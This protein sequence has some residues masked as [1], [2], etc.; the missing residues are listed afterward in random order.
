[1]KIP[2]SLP[3]LL[4]EMQALRSMGFYSLVAQALI[5][6]AG[7]GLVIGLFR[8]LYTHINAFIV[9]SLSLHNLYSLP[10]ICGLFA[11]LTLLALISGW[12]VTKEPLLSGSGIPQVELTVRGHLPLP[13][14][15]LLLG[16]FVGTLLCL[17]GGLSVGREGPSIQMGAAVG[18]GVGSLWFGKES[19]LPRFLIAGSA[20]GMTAAFGAPCAGLLFAFEEMKTV[21]TVPLLLFTACAAGAAFMVIHLLFGFG[22]VYPFAHLAPLAWQQ[23]PLLL[24][25]AAIVGFIGAGYNGALMGGLFFWDKQKLFSSRTR[26]LIPFVC[27]GLLLYTYPQVLVGF[28]ISIESLEHGTMLL[29]S[30]LVLLGVKILFSILSFSSGVSGGLLMPMLSIGAMAGACASALALPFGLIQADQLGTVLTL[31]MGALFAATVRAPLTGGM[32]V[33][34]MTGA[35]STAPAMLVAVYTA[36]FVAN[37]LHSAP[38]YDSIKV[39]LLK[40]TRLARHKQA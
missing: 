12:I 5:V 19:V 26:P 32:L 38:I 30:L 24:V 22:L 3:P 16:K 27:S 4:R 2:H 1:M 21:L 9:H 17:S 10:W 23:Y 25:W 18:C 35:W 29:G 14:L 8:W 31:S 36:T 37:H 13:W 33:L 40:R 39:R 7:T 15:R 11:T 34:E 20:A 6:G 28:G